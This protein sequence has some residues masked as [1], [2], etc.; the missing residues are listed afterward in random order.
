MAT[1]NRYALLGQVVGLFLPF[2]FAWVAGL[3]N[4]DADGSPAQTRRSRHIQKFNIKAERFALIIVPPAAE[5]G[6]DGTR[7]LQVHP[8]A[9]PHR[10]VGPMT[11]S[12]R[13]LVL[14]V[15]ALALIA[16]T[17]GIVT[18]N[19]TRF[20]PATTATA[21]DRSLALTQGCGLH[22]TLPVRRGP[23]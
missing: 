8:A 15:F 1:T 17:T 23:G 5:S 14:A 6:H 22:A 11:L 4:V 18:L 7:V 10:I 19:S 21:A 9:V 12:E 2:G 16:G 13:I 3:S 20:T